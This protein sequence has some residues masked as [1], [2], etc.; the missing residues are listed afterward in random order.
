MRR[1]VL[2]A[3]IALF[4]CAPRRAGLET[5]PYL[6]M[7]V[8]AG[9][10]LRS[11]EVE[12]AGIPDRFPDGAPSADLGSGAAG[13]A[14]FLAELFVATGD[15]SF[16][17]LAVRE[18]ERGVAAPGRAGERHGLYNGLAGIAFAAAMVGKVAGEPVLV[19]SGRR[20]FHEVARAAPAGSAG[21]WG[22]AY[23][24]LAGAAGIGLALLD[25]HRRFGDSAFLDAAVAAGDALLGAVD[26]LPGGQVRW[27][28][29]AETPLDLPNF[30]HGTA[31]VGYFLTRL[32]TATGQARFADGAQTAVRYLDHIADRRDGLFLVPYGVPNDDYAT[33]YDIGWAH[34]PAGTARLH[35]ALWSSSRDPALKATVEAQARA[36]RASG[37]PGA[38]ADS[39]IW[40]GPFRLDRRFG[41]S[42]AAVFLLDWGHEAGVDSHVDLGRRLADGLLAA[43]TVSE[44]GAQWRVPLYGF[45]GGEGEA[46]FTGYFYGSA[47]LGL[48]LLHAHYSLVGQWPRIRFP[49]DP[50]PRGSRE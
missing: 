34:G 3:L 12:A 41:T 48:A 43:A 24:V 46:S 9:A 2:F 10:W 16:R 5:E 37:A 50:F 32:A 33:P 49:D 39:T 36:I 19:A 4:G 7:A 44:D 6:D 22:G 21:E 1:L 27:L 38:T 42:G 25:A 26:S 47:G 20:L 23:D 31:G 45:Q 11:L 17:D 18:A 28:R 40:R 15:R 8:R 13:R 30:S 29:G 35:Y 14:L